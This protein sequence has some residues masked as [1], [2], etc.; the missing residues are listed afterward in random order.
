MKKIIFSQNFDLLASC[1]SAALQETDNPLQKQWIL[2]PS[3]FLKQ[4]LFVQLAKKSPT[5]GIAGY[6]ICTLDA[7]FSTRFSQIPKP[8]EMRCLIYE[9]LSQEW[10]PEVSVFLA[11]FKKNRMHLAD[12]LASL[13]FSYGKYGL[14]LGGESWQIRLFKA[15]FEN[16]K[17]HLPF[18]L[19]PHEKWE[20]DVL[21]C[22]GFDS[23][24]P[25]FWL[26]LQSA[27]S[28]LFYSFSPCYH[29]WE[30]V[31]TD[32]EQ[33]KL[34]REGKR[35][36]VSLH[37]LT[38]MDA[39]LSSAPSLL[40]NLGKLARETMKSFDIQLL[41]AEIAY[42]PLSY[43]TQ[44]SSIQAGIVSFEK[45]APKKDLPDD[46]IQIFQTGAS[47]LREVEVVAEEIL[48]LVYNKGL[49]F[50][51]MG[52]FA[53]DM[54][55][56]IP[57]LEC[58]FSQK[59]I[60]YRF[61]SVSVERKSPFYQGIHRL[62]ALVKGKWNQENLCTLFEN[63]A[64]FR[65]A[66]FD[67]QEIASCTQWICEALQHTSDWESGFSKWLTSSLT[68]FPSPRREVENLSQFDLLEQCVGLL[69]S[70]HEDCQGMLEE[71]SLEK[72]A[73]KWEEMAEKYLCHDSSDEIDVA[74][75]ESFNAMI[76]QMKRSYVQGIYPFEVI[77]DC[78]LKPI[79]SSIHG[80]H[81]HA[82]CCA[83]MQEGAAV[84][85][86]A[87]F[88]MGMD[89]ESF[90]RKKQPSSLDLARKDP[91]PSD[92]DRYSFLQLLLQ[93]QEFLRVS[94][95]HVSPDDGRPIGPSIVVQELMRESF[96][97]IVVSKP[98]IKN[99]APKEFL[100]SLECPSPK[101]PCK[102][103]ALS[104]ADLTAFARHP[105]KYYLK[106]V[107]RIFL[108]DRKER[109]F[110]SARS[111]L[112]RASL[113]WPLESVF[114]SRKETL[115]AR[116]D[117]AFFLDV[118]EKRREFQEQLGK[119]GKKMCSFAFLETAREPSEFLPLQ[120]GLSDGS[121]VSLKGEIPLALEDG[122]LHLG[123]DKISSLLKVWP[124]VLALLTALERSEIYFLKSGKIKSVQNPKESLQR[125]IEYFLLCEESLSPL[126][127]DWADVL[128]RKKAEDFSAE[129]AYEDAVNEWMMPRLDLPEADRLFQNWG[130]L[131]TSFEGL[132]SLYPTRGKN[133]QV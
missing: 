47:L 104:L 51:E 15:L 1:L 13:F 112:V 79:H 120:I 12:H 131:K 125:F 115:P 95:R 122:A 26:F 45:M 106:K 59:E 28:H 6:K 16:S 48:N 117:E 25:L 124:E 113:Q 108:Q 2:V 89:E 71:R 35:K 110:A 133:E 121:I 101:A 68:L 93:A 103:R 78:F 77:E 76:R 126:I 80:N 53:P 41:D 42:A 109:S 72:W 127:P 60:P 37:S 107:E 83:S 49:K 102:N 86:R 130:W 118:E 3:V 21:H 100:F 22:F 24:P 66:R 119:W 36:G 56:Y 55:P 94:Y 114:S 18:Q 88:M 123:D 52:L 128:L 62:F 87:I 132:I 19:L 85:F 32:F 97:E 33:S 99:E 38:Q 67:S 50:S 98:C 9:A 69:Q 81:L 116:F 23:L 31:R 43:N 74:A 29:F 75:W 129:F 63:C 58:I 61:P 82:V 57:F 11:R 70:L 30:D 65:K 92:I 54:G 91:D 40:A 10:S 73:M 20:G 7:I 14:P 4:W 8:F 90:P 39:Y 111:G 84:P 64:F 96:V 27:P 44:L 17:F 105:W 34:M 5:E 46:S